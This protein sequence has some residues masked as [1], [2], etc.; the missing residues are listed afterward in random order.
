MESPAQGLSAHKLIDTLYDDN[1]KLLH[2]NQKHIANNKKLRRHQKRFC[3]QYF[4]YQ[5]NIRIQIG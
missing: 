1:A 2:S 4:D 5:Y 3:E